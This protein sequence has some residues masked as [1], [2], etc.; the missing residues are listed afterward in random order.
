MNEV[1]KKSNQIP[2]DERGQPVRAHALIMPTSDARTQGRLTGWVKTTASEPRVHFVLTS[3]DATNWY[4]RFETRPPP[5]A[6]SVGGRVMRIGGWEHALELWRDD[7][8]AASSPPHATDARV[9]DTSF[10]VSLLQKAVRRGET[11]VAKRAAHELAHA[12]PHALVRRLPII[13]IEDVAAN[14]NL[15][16]VVWL[17]LH[18]SRGAQLTRDDVFWLVAYA[19]ALSVDPRR[20]DVRHNAVDI[21]GAKTVWSRASEAADHGAMALVARTAY[22]GMSGDM[23]MLLRAAQGGLFSAP[24]LNVIALPFDDRLV[25]TDVILAAVDFHCEPDMNN[26]LAKVHGVDPGEI[27]AAIWQND[28]CVNIRE[29]VPTPDDPALYQSIREQLDEIRRRRIDRA[30][31]NKR[32][33]TAIDVPHATP[34][35]FR[36]LDSFLGHS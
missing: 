17:M 26:I 22:G 25:H 30:F 3:R 4:A 33:A 7:G 20:E 11:L 19:G 29:P 18:V 24:S 2:D 12:D 27:K 36:R 5:S 16:V 28:S 34:S 21:L 6:K 13:A 31:R 32:A 8:E 23:G 1:E 15:P 9:K 35:A 14:S 10:L